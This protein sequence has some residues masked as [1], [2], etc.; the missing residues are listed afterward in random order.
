MFVPITKVDAKERLVYGVLAS[1]V[2]DKTGEVFDY[3]TSKP[4]VETWSGE[5]AKATDG[6]SVGNLREMHGKSAAGKFVTL[7][8]DDKGKSINVCAKVIDDEAWEKVQEGVY[9]GF[10][11]GGS[12]EKKWTDS[13]G[14]KRYTAKP[15]EGS[16]V[17]NPANPDTHF[18]M[19]KADGTTLEKNFKAHAQAVTEPVTAPELEQ[20]WKTTADGQTFATKA[21]AK[22]HKDDLDAARA[23][24]TAALATLDKISAMVTEALEKRD[25]S[26]KERAKAAEKG[27]AMPDGSYPIKN[28]DDMANA[29]QAFGR[30]KNKKAVK[31]HIKTRAKAMGA[32][33]ALPA[34]WKDD[35]AGKA[36]RTGELRKGLDQVARL[37][38][39]LQELDWLQESTEWEAEREGD[40]SKVP[41]ALKQNIATVA[42]SLRE[43]TEEETNE[44][45]DDEEMLDFGEMLEMSFRPAGIDALAKRMGEKAPAWLVKVGA[46]HSKADQFHFDAAHDHIAKLVGGDCSKYVDAPEG[47]DKMLKAGAR[48]SKATMD[49]LTEAHK[50]MKDA[51]AAC[52]GGMSKCAMPV[53]KSDAGP[54]IGAAV[55]SPDQSAGHED[56]TKM[57]KMLAD[58]RAKTDKLEKA[59]EGLQANVEKLLSLPVVHP[60]DRAPMPNRLVTKAD[61]TG[62]LSGDMA[63]NLGVSPEELEKMTEHEFSAR[64]T[65]M[66]RLRGRPIGR[67]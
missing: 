18:T 37:A 55:V 27:E 7:E 41:S 54:D 57:A 35:E 58:E 29:V 67:Q 8:C 34:S 46:K 44:L 14:L 23:N 45:L 10:S 51:G 5:I 38:M 48:H 25:F 30:A 40:D 50:C 43:M 64:L 16:L 42:A 2:V 52:P 28:K 32:T 36:L 31:A 33:D 17:D 56:H 53:D 61:D 24:G 49:L 59:I 66:A 1:E 21:L 13:E 12:Y 22:A 62:D 15:S 3:E 20:V 39:I 26:D 65:A 47:Y 6:K 63:K 4:H 19:V 60:R 9:T 11:I